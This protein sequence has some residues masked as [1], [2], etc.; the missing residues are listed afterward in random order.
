MPTCLSGVT[1]DVEYDK[2]YYRAKEIEDS[3]GQ[4]YKIRPDIL[5]HKREDNLN[6]Q[7]AIECK[8]SYLNKLDKIKLKKLLEPSYSHKL[9]LG[10]SYQPQKKYLLFYVPMKTNFE[11]FHFDKSKKEMKEGIKAIRAST[12]NQAT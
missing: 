6:N 9:S 12:D 4:T 3:D 8:K 1:V 2:N 7:I 10:I 11:I 5:V